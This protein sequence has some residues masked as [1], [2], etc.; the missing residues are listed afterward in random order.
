MKINSF[1]SRISGISKSW[2]NLKLNDTQLFLN[3]K[4]SNLNFVSALNH[5]Y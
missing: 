5:F 1:I 4:M 2:I 3:N